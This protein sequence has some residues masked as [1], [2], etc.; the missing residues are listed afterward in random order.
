MRLAA[1]LG[2]RPRNQRSLVLPAT[3]SVVIGRYTLLEGPVMNAHLRDCARWN[4]EGWSPRRQFAGPAEEPLVVAGID[5]GKPMI[6]A[7]DLE[8]ELHA[9]PVC[10][11][12]HTELNFR[13][14][15]QGARF[16]QCSVC[17]FL[18]V[19]PRPSAP[20]LEAHYEDYGQRIF[21]DERRLITDFEP[22]RFDIEWGLVTKL[23]GK[24]LD[25]GC[26]TGAFV[27]LAQGRGFL[28]Q[29]ID[30]SKS[31]VEYGRQHGLS[32][33]CGDF[34]AD[35]FDADAFDVVT[36]WATLEHLSEPRAFL[37]SAWR[38]L[39]PSGAVVISVPNSDSI[40]HRM[41]GQRYRYIGIDHLNY[42]NSRTLAR[43]IDRCGFRVEHVETR[44]WNPWVMFQDFRGAGREGASVERQMTDQSVTD[45]LKS[46][47]GLS[48]VRAVHAL[49]ERGIAQIG[50]GE[51]LLMR[52]IKE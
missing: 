45:R 16:W 30:T 28:A 4:H 14:A 37:A 3:L 49:A 12:S 31:A 19:A 27:Q 9:C 21:L 41:L 35:I 18:F 34:A 22:S 11:A 43:L 52:A 7:D 39:R 6:E 32:L 47:P 1:Q 10:D 23:S 25:V 20:M 33:S 5:N 44:K 26:S 17:G 40:S 36:M 42:F 29:G 48:V 8:R 2:W 38:V 13:W 24:L 50:A 46:A 51:L 15:K